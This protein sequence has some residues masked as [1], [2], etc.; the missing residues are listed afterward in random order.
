MAK[1]D[2]KKEAAKPVKK[3]GHPFIWGITI[4]LLV[5]VILG[6]WFRPPESFKVDELKKATE[7]KIESG[8]EGSKE[9]AADWAEAL[10][11]K[12]RDR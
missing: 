3:K 6:W 2:G 5:G 9:K 1:D 8:A 7:K 10:A 4:G 12:L 11:K